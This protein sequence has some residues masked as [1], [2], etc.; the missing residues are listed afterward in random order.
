MPV[1]QLTHAQSRRRIAELRREGCDVAVITYESGDKTVMKGCPDTLLENPPAPNAVGYLVLAAFAG[2][3]LYAIFRPKAAAAS[4]PAPT[5]TPS[6]ML[7]TEADFDRLEE[8]ATTNNI[9]VVYL[10]ATIT[11]PS[12][13]TSELAAGIVRS[14]ANLVVVTGDGSFWTYST[15][16]PVLAPAQR[17]AYCNFKPSIAVSGIGWL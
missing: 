2:A 8:W 10:P 5:P 14:A 13:A 1:P 16:E 4:T 7:E 17:E 3:A 6:C 15:G 11:P 12:P 9:G